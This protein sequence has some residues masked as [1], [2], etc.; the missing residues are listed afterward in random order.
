MVNYWLSRII[1]KQAVRDINYILATFQGRT[2]KTLDQ[3]LKDMRAA[4]LNYFQ[5]H[6]GCV[7][8]FVHD[9]SR[10]DYRFHIE[11]RGGILTK[12]TFEE[13]D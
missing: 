5:T 13:K 6:P 10:L 11:E 4:V 2:S 8:Y 1:K 3:T 9:G 7:Q 12:I